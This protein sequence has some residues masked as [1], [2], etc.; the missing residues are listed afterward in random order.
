M[1]RPRPPA[2]HLRD[3]LAETEGAPHDEYASIDPNDMPDRLGHVVPRSEAWRDHLV[4]K[5]QRAKNGPGTVVVTSPIAANVATY[6]RHHPKW[7]GVVAYDEFREC[8][9]CL[10]PPPWHDEDRPSRVEAGAWTDGDTPRLRAW[11]VRTDGLDVPLSEVEQGLAMA[12]DLRRVHPVRDYLTAL[13]WD[14][15]KRI[16]TWLSAYAGTVDTLYER[17]VGSRWLISAVARIFEPGCQVDCTLI[18]EGRTGLGKTSAFR[19]LVPVPEWYADS[20]IDVTNK[21]SFDALRAVWIYGLDELDSL[22]KG[23]VTRWKNFLTAIRDHYRP[24]YG[25]RAKDFLRQNVFGGTTNEE[26]YFVDRTGNRRFWPVRVTREVDRV[27]L[28]RDRD[29]LWAEAVYEYRAGTK[30]YVDLPGLRELCE[31]QQAERLQRDPWVELIAEWLL[32]PAT[33]ETSS[34]GGY[35]QTRLVPLDL[36]DGVSVAEVLEHCL[37]VR[38][39]DIIPHHQQRVGAA[40]RDLGYVRTRPHREHGDAGRAYRYVRAAVDMPSA[41][42]DHEAD[43]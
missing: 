43:D 37:H 5:E 42:A 18:L 39:A 30:W 41:V 34:D 38:R 6:L 13:A 14:G 3:L 35:Q 23:D 7:A 9:V 32:A 20:G 15:V 17:G 29:Q 12:A 8:T 21:D 27:A 4:R 33:R 1:S 24:P 22:R 16:D 28:V 19:E 40:L 26:E 36:R 10:R 2:P 11:L 25:H 31:S